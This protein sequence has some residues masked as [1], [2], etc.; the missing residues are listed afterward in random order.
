MKNFKKVTCIIGV[1]ILVGL[2]LLSLISAIYY[3]EGFHNIFKASIYN[4]VVVPVLVYAMLLMYR[5][6]SKK[7]ED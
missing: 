4:S 6:L 5:V 2:Y 7:K 1:I 3:K